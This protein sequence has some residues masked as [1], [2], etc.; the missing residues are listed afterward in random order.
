MFVYLFACS[1]VRIKKY[2]YQNVNCQV[3]SYSS[4][5]KAQS[6]DTCSYGAGQE[7]VNCKIVIH[8]SFNPQAESPVH[9][10]QLHVGF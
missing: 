4:Q 1:W 10:R 5:L 7:N 8:L 3:Y 9:T 2:H 6:C